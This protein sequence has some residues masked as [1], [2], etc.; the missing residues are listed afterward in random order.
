MVFSGNEIILKT[1]HTK[2]T[3]A[4]PVNLGF[5]LFFV[6]FVICDNR[7]L[8][9][10]VR[11]LSLILLIMFPD[12]LSGLN[13]VIRIRFS[14][15]HYVDTYVH[16]MIHNALLH[17]HKRSHLHNSICIN[18]GARTSEGLCTHI[19]IHTHVRAHKHEYTYICIWLE[20]PAKL[21]N[22]TFRRR[23]LVSAFSARN[24]KKNIV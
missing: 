22:G 10:F 1:S 3:L 24:K 17:V 18:T 9:F 5:C 19:Y 2:F 21:I 13:R 16:K 7:K 6:S 4:W 15:M 12:I 8:E 14:T 11:Q 20:K 23:L